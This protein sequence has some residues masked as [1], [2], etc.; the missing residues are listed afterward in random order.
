MT[1]RSA[2]PLTCVEM[3]RIA[4]DSGI[5]WVQYRDKEQ[6]RL[7][8]YRNALLLRRITRQYNACFI[9]NDHADI[10]RAVSADGVHLGQDDLPVR[11]A[12][13]I[14]GRGRIIGISTHSV[15]E[16]QTAERDGADYIGYGPIY[17]TTTKNAGMPRGADSIAEIR[18]HVRI[19]VVAIGG[20]TA[21]RLPELFSSGVMAVAVA[22]GILKGHLPENASQFLSTARLSQRLH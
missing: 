8:L 9:I 2:C 12:R 11:E 14:M 18:K 3:V 1:D 4:L 16:A 10:A 7:S 15:E 21:E 19:P 20:I 17:H 6:S 13:R 22:S 5:R